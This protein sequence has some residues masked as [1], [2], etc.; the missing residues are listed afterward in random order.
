MRRGLRRV[1]VSLADFSLGVRAA[2]SLGVRAA[3]SL[4]V[5]VV[6]VIAHSA[7]VAHRV[8]AALVARSR[9]VPNV[10]AY[11]FAYALWLVVWCLVRRVVFVLVVVV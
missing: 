10:F 3:F 8:I 9:R 4:G 5:R 6:V 2:F 11:V 1:D 7:E